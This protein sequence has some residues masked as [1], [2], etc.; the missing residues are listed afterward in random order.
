MLVSL[1]QLGVPMALNQK[2]ID[3]IKK[4]VSKS[5]ETA[6]YNA[7]M[8][9]EWGDRGAG[10]S[11]ERL[12]YWLDG[13]A[14]ATTGNTELYDHIISQHLKESDP[15]YQKYLELKEKFEKKSR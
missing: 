6:R 4:A 5:A 13:I 2:H 15:D 12:K 1:C 7:G 9:G 3:L 10:Q 11:E 8:G 14:Y